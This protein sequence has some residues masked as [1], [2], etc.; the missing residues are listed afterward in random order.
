MLMTSP[1][2]RER[3]KR[4]L[5]L[6]QVADLIRQLG[7]ERGHNV[8]IDGNSVSRH[9]RGVI[10]KPRHPYP[11]LYSELYGVPVEALWPVGRIDGMDRRRFL[12]SLAA[13]TGGVLLDG[14]QDDLEAL[15]A[16]TS[17]LRSL[18][19]TTPSGELWN[20]VVGHLR[21]VGQ[22][23]GH[24]SRYAEE[25]AEVARL[26]A[27][28]AWDQDHQQDAQQMYQRAIRYARQSGDERTIGF[29]EGSR[30][31]WM[32]ETGRGAEAVRIGRPLPE[33]PSAWFSTMRATVA[34][35]AGDTDLTISSLKDA[36]RLVRSPTDHQKVLGYTGRAY[37]RLGLSRAAETALREAVQGMPEVKY[38]GVLLTELAR[39]VGTEE[40]TQLRMEARQLGGR[41][42]SRRVLAAVR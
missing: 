41:L 25:A 32:A 13:T 30:A 10:T 7:H 39:V 35:A 8:G 9:E 29:M 4:N 19:P 36:E 18:E 40:A 23:A 27:W 17:G 14:A 28:L 33:A 6:E 38:K 31:L 22:R 37:L 34:S 15:Q 24:G 11:L 3:E 5:T 1:L 12:Q 16:I 2:R 21:M 42:R 20:P 26:A